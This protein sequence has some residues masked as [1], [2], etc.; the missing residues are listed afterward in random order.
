MDH[1][2]FEHLADLMH[3][4]ASLEDALV[5]LLVRKKSFGLGHDPEEKHVRIV[6]PHSGGPATIPRAAC[7][8]AKLAGIAKPTRDDLLRALKSCVG[9]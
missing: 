8:R 7:V 4:G 2:D 1:S 3:D 6:L 5:S 9:K